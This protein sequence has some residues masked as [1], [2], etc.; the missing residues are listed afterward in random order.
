MGTVAAL[1]LAFIT[2]NGICYA[3]TGQTW[4]S[5]AMVYINGQ[6][7]EAE[8]TWHKEGDRVYGEMEVDVEEGTATRVDTFVSITDDV[9]NERTYSISEE[10]FLEDEEVFPVEDAIMAEVKEE[11]EKVY[12]ITEIE[13]VD[14]T[15]DFRDGEATG[16]FVYCGLTMRYIVTGTVEKYEISITCE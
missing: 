7:T 4:I 10:V 1:V 16:S 12:L 13:K 9:Q 11:E 8:I 14:I 5:K 15:E 3:A 2:S 6:A